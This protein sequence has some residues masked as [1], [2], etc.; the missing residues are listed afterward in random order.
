LPL[1]TCFSGRDGFRSTDVSLSAPLETL[2]SSNAVA[3]TLRTITHELSHTY[4]ADALSVLAPG[5]A[6]QMDRMYALFTDRIEPRSLLD[7]VCKY[8]ATGFWW[9]VHP[10]HASEVPPDQ[11]REAIMTFWVEAQEI[12]TDTFD[13]LYF[14]RGDAPAY[15]R[16]TWVS[17][18][19][20][21][22]IA[23][24]IEEYVTRTL[25]A[26]AAVNLRAKKTL[27]ATVEQLRTLLTTLHAEF[28]EGLYVKPALDDLSARPDHYRRRLDDR[29]PFV[30]IVRHFLYSPVI[31]KTLI[32]EPGARGRRAAGGY[33]DQPLT[34][35]EWR[36]ANPLRFLNTFSD[37]KQPNPARSFWLLH[38]L[39]HGD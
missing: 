1:I 35:A 27:D 26:L 29:S 16:A 10:E 20:V 33:P 37:D 5:D 4:I 3:W 8:L 13:F 6:D 12:M 17:W 30:R 22:N 2:T 38:Q 34:F 11:F 19:V 32:E 36:V 25:C 18:G 7:S 28:P 31:E 24:R 21:P 9:S 14:H 23:H 15:V 39:A